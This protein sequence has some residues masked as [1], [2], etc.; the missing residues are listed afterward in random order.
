MAAQVRGGWL[1]RGVDGP[2]GRGERLRVRVADRRQLRPGRPRSDRRAANALGAERQQRLILFYSQ[3]GTLRGSWSPTG[4]ETN[5]TLGELHGPL[6]P[7]QSD[8]LMLDGIDMISNDLPSDPPPALPSMPPSVSTK[9]PDPEMPPDAPP[10]PSS[11]SDDAAASGVDA[12][13]GA[14]PFF[15][16]GGYQRR[17]LVSS[18]GTTWTNDVSDPP[19]ANDNI[20]NGVAFG[21]GTVLVTGHT[22]A[23]TSDDK[24]VTWKKVPPPHA[25]PGLGGSAAA[26]GNGTFV[27][28]A[29]NDSWQSLCRPSPLDDCREAGASL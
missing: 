17:R 21:R 27:I 4:T 1:P 11:N 16:A 14:T 5:F 28:V 15:V 19:D 12:A 7:Y 26:F 18:D 23:S 9:D 20:V 25:W 13:A 6:K 3:H 29:G 24:G 22:G 8:L 10:R 2:P